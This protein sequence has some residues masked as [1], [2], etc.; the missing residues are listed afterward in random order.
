MKDQDG[1]N[2]GAKFKALNAI[3][4]NLQPPNLRF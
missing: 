2:N 4:T 3:E 1:S